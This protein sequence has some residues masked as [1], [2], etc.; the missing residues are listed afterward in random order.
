M[1]TFAFVVPASYFVKG[2]SDVVVEA[3]I[4]LE[5]LAGVNLNVLTFVVTALEFPMPMP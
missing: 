5:V 1:A 4:D 2:L 3:N